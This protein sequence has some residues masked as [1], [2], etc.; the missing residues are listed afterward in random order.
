MKTVGIIIRV[1]PIITAVLVILIL[2]PG[3]SYSWAPATHA[4]ME[5]Q[6][7]KQQG[8]LK[9]QEKL[10]DF[11][12][13]NNR[14]YG[15]TALDIFNFSFSSPYPQCSAYLHDT[16]NPNFLKVW[17]ALKVSEN[18]SLQRAF[19]YGFVGHNNTWGMDSTAH[20]SG[21]TYGRGEGYVIAKAS[22]LVPLLK[23][24]DEFKTLESQLG[25][26]LPYEVMLNVCHYLIEYGV[27][28]LVLNEDTSI[29]G[30]LFDAAAKRDPADPTLLIAAYADDQDFKDL[31]APR[32]AAGFITEAE[33]MFR[34]SMLIYGKALAPNPDEA[35]ANI[36]IFLT[37]FGENY[38]NI[39]A[40]LLKPVVT[41]GLDIAMDI[42]ASDFE[43]EIK[44]STGWVNGKLSSNGISW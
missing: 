8:K 41:R 34:N 33:A 9:Q 27:D 37:V 13:L 5:K 28:L 17:D 4:H 26:E 31:V 2:I 16:E 24:T 1:V 11:G 14:I 39:P 23:E 6:F 7:Y 40:A 30:T 10:D 3:R 19:A 15:A 18:T 35:R 20:I 21:I 22:M 32:D 43:R 42:C 36:I 44:A 29:G 38:L 12:I 25:G